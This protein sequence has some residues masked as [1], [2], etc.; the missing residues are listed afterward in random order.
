[1]GTKAKK[2]GKAPLWLKV[3]FGGTN[4][5]KQYSLSSF[6]TIGEL[7]LTATEGEWIVEASRY[8]KRNDPR[9]TT[10]K[11]IERSIDD[12]KK[13]LK[14]KGK[15][16]TLPGL[17]KAVFI[18]AD[19]SSF[20]GLIDAQ[21]KELED[22][23]RYSYAYIFK[24]ARN[25]V[26]RFTKDKDL[27]LSE[28]DRKWL[29]RFDWH[30]QQRSCTKNTRSVY[31]RNIRR[32]INIGIE[33]GI[34]NASQYPFGKNGFKIGSSV[35]KKRAIAKEHMLAIINT[36]VP[37]EMRN[38]QNYFALSYLGG[39][40]NFKDMALWRWDANVN[41]NRIVFA[42]SKTQ[43]KDNQQPHSIALSG[44]IAEIL[45]EYTYT[46]GY[47]LPVIFSTNQKTIGH[48]IKGVLKR[49]NKDLK[50]IA[51]MVGVPNPDQITFYTARHTFATV[52]KDSGHSVEMIKELLGHEDIKTT[53]IYLGSFDDAT[54]DA[55]FEDLL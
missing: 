11:N 31:M 6:N 51:R 13:E 41:N 29:E 39:G 52:L 25:A 18:L 36:E 10:L 16:F 44:R 47:V 40:V 35:A 22:T 42:R 8:K 45:S 33:K 2:D 49:T 19:T 7:K 37:D 50:E 5:R 54:K 20:N 55:A 34:L 30:L 9:N 4:K 1:M 43:R 48:Q 24:D 17:E 15:T 12:Y 32:I 3:Q 23:D 53:Q 26:N 14:D 27:P 21:I 38:S 28:I 46:P